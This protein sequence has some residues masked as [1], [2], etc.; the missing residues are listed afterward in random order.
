[1]KLK[2]ILTI[3]AGMAFCLLSCQKSN[4]KPQD[5]DI[6]GTWHETGLHTVQTINGTTTETNLSAGDFN[7]SDYAQFNQDNTAAISP[8]AGNPLRAEQLLTGFKSLIIV[9]KFQD[10]L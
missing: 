7:G 9:I 10:R 1:M 8:G 2:C 3:V 5:A 6:V 4:F